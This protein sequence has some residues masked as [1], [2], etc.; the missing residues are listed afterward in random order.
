MCLV[1]IGEFGDGKTFQSYLLGRKLHERFLKEPEAGIVVVRY[2]LRD[3]DPK[4]GVQSSIEARLRQLDATLSSWNALCR[5]HQVL[6]VLDGFD[7]M[8][9]PLDRESVTASIIQ[10]EQWVKTLRAMAPNQNLKVLITSRPHFFVNLRD[11]KRLLS[12]LGNPDVLRLSPLSI[13]SVW[14]NLSSFATTEIQRRDLRRLT[15]LN[16]PI[17]LATKPLYLQMVKS[18]LANGLPP[19]T[20]EIDG[21]DGVVLYDTYVRN[22]LE[23]KQELLD[24]RE[25]KTLPEETIEALEEIL[26]IVAVALQ[27]TRENYVLLAELPGVDEGLAYLLWKA[28]FEASGPQKQ[29]EEDALARVGVRSLLSTL[30]SDDPKIQ[31]RWPVDFCHR[32][33]REYFTARALVRELRTENETAAELLRSSSLSREVIEFAAVLLRRDWGPRIV[34]LLRNAAIASAREPPESRLGA[35]A[36]SLLFAATGRLEDDDWAGLRLDY[37]DLAGADLSGKNFQGSSMCHARLDNTSLAKADFRNCDLTGVVIEQTTPVRALAPDPQGL[38]AIYSDQSVLFWTIRGR[39]DAYRKLAIPFGQP[40]EAIG[41]GPSTVIWCKVGD[42][43]VVVS[44]PLE[45]NVTSRFQLADRLVGF[46]SHESFAALVEIHNHESWRIQVVDLD[47]LSIL[48]THELKEEPLCCAISAG[49]LA[50][51]AIT[52]GIV[53]VEFDGRYTHVKLPSTPTQLAIVTGPSQTQFWLAYGT[54][55][56]QLKIIVLERTPDAPISHNQI[57]ETEAHDGEVTALAYLSRG[58]LCSGGLDRQVLVHDFEFGEHDLTIIRTSSHYRRLDC[59]GIKT[60]GMIP[61]RV[62]NTLE[63][64]AR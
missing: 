13:G 16:D 21:L 47:K 52:G 28:A 48:T 10:L 37:V 19:L 54:L 34:E 57:F 27:K 22:A 29:D 38:I 61:S 4:L 51:V 18:S 15:K 45:E 26:E 35:N 59:Q 17:G 6:A 53:V 46:A 32:S 44:T 30:R 49:G 60:E 36:M 12:R 1:L 50:V 58:T 33:I 62:R 5:Q 9:L 8:S 63:K 41:H 31:S 64:L 11:E 43:F 20:D 40:V 39:R 56:G 25:R 42:E 14:N 7:E 2:P 55:S 23:A 24:D 3:F